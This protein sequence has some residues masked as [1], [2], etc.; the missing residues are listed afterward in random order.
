[1]DFKCVTVNG[2]IYGD[3]KNFKPSLEQSR[4]SNVDFADEQLIHD[5]NDPRRAEKLKEFMFSLALCHTVVVSSSNGELIYSASS[6]D[7]LALINFSRFCG[8]EYLGLDL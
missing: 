3:E 2:K 6:P 5:L 1:M 8:F 7:E 4:I